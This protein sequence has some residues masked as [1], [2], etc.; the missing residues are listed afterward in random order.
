MNQGRRT[1]CELLGHHRRAFVKGGHKTPAVP[2]LRM[3][4]S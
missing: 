1:G 2:D 4:V 3:S